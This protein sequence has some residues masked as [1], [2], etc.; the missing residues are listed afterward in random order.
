MV[1]CEPHRQQPAGG[2]RQRRHPGILRSFGELPTYLGQPLANEL[3]RPVDIRS[4][5]EDDRDHRQAL[6]G[7]R[8]ENIE[9]GETVDRGLN[10]QG[11]ELFDFAWGEPGGLCLNYDLGRGEFGEDIELGMAGGVNAQHQEEYGQ[12]YNDYAVMERPS[13]DGLQHVNRYPLRSGILPR[14]APGRAAT[15]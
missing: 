13:D 11:D 14:E 4:I 3:P 9:A 12:R 8:A 15:R 2:R 7:L 1:G 6:D 10:R 5:L